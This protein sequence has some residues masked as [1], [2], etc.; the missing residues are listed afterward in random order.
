MTRSS[1]KELIEPYN[2]PER[3]LNSLTKLFKTTSFEHS[4]LPEFELFS[5]YVESILKVLRDNTFS[6]LENEDANEHTER[7]LEIVDLF[8]TPDV[9]HGQLML[10][11]F[12]ISLIVAASRWL[13]NEPAGSITTREILKGN[14]LSKYCPPS[15]SILFY[16]GLDVPIRQILNSKGGVPIIK[17]DDAKKAIQ[18]MANYSQKW[19]NGTSNRNKSRNTSDGL[20]GIQAQLNDLSREIKKVNK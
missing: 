20:A 11:V 5:D 6:G 14:F 13:R 16:K 17:A 15:R 18:E 3:V 4:S 8:T 12:P 7:V 19:H 9:T 10:C 1:N 2:E